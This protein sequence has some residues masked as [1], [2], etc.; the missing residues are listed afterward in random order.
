MNSEQFLL[1]V[2]CFTLSVINLVFVLKTFF[3]V[4]SLQNEVVNQVH[5]KDND[6]VDVHVDLHNRL[7]QIQNSRY[8]RQYMRI[9]N[10]RQQ[11]D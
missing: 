5:V 3:A 8:A 6:E 2:A 1:V 7:M 9:H 11:N 10:M 4:R